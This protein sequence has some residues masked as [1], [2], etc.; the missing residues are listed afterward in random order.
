MALALINLQI[1]EAQEFENASPDDLPPVRLSSHWHID[2][3]IFNFL[4]G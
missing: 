2:I 3:N 1:C 4:V